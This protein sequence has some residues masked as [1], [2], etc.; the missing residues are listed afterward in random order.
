MCF[1]FPFS[2][3]VYMHEVLYGLTLTSLFFRRVK[4]CDKE[5]YVLG[6]PVKKDINKRSFV[7]CFKQ[8]FLND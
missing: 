8:K 5:I 7:I 6:K 1:P 3:F 4:W 2:L